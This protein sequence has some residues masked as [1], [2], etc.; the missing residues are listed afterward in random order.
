L[1][2]PLFFVS[3]VFVLVVVFEVVVGDDV[4]EDVVLVLLVEFL[5]VIVGSFVPTGLVVVVVVVV[6]VPFANLVVFVIRLV[7]D[8]ILEL[9]F[10]PAPLVPTIC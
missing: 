3:V 7:S 9:P 2:Q 1:L 5:G 8:N 6:V 4:V 10:K